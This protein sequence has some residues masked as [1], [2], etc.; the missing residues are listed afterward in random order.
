MK[1]PFTL[2]LALA[3]PL[4]AT[5]SLVS[6]ARADVPPPNLKGCEMKKAADA[7]MNDEDKPGTCVSQTCTKL[8]YSMGTPPTSVD[9]DCILCSGPAPTSE[10]SGGSDT[11]AESTGCSFG[12]PGA[13]PSSMS[14]AAAIA[15]ALLLMR[16][17]R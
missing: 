9:Y 17:R 11:D 13:A 10:S 8:D 6:P 1:A 12:A 14:A 7:C 4:L 15:A 16:R 3:L 5:L 2:A